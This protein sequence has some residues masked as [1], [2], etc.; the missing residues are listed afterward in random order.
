MLKVVR[1][2]PSPEEIAALMAVLLVTGGDGAEPEPTA[3]KAS[4]ARARGFGAPA[5]SWRAAS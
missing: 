1:G 3:A 2:N 4:W 5:G